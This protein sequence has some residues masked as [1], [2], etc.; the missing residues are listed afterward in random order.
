MPGHQSIETEEED[1]HYCHDHEHEH[2]LTNGMR[3][4]AD[5]VP[6]MTHVFTGVSTGEL[7]PR[8]DKQDDLLHLTTKGSILAFDHVMMEL[9]VSRYK[10]S[11]RKR[12][13]EGGDIVE[14]WC[15]INR[16]SR[17]IY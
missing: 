14:L 12:M 15:H 2:D 1:N 8:H 3:V 13:Y 5:Q 6:R 9:H 17:R 11:Y 16:L 10:V 7:S 4:A